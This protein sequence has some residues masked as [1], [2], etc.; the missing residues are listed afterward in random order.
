M[1]YQSYTVYGPNGY[2]EYHIQ[3]KT[4]GEAKRIFKK[5]TGLKAMDAEKE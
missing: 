2:T 4:K 5:E 1:A 3:A